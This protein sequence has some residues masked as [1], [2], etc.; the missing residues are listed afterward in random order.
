VIVATETFPLASVDNFNAI[1]D[2]PWVVGAFIW[3]AIDYIG[4]SVI[5]ANGHSPPD[6]LA[7]GDYC[8]QPWSYHIS[9]CGDLDVVGGQK[10]QAYLRRVLWNVSALEM[11]VKPA[12]DGEVIAAWGFPDERQ[13]WSWDVP[14]RLMQ[15]NVYSRAAVC[16]VVALNGKNVSSG[17]MPISRDTDYTLTIKV[18]YVPGTLTATGF[19][20]AGRVLATRSFVTAGPAAR[21]RLT[22]DRT[23]ISPSRAD[24]S[25]VV[26]EVVDAHGVLVT[27]ANESLGS[28][29]VPPT[30]RFTLEGDGE[31]AAVGSADP[32]DPSSFYAADADSAM[33]RKS[34]RGRA[35]AIVRPGKGAAAD[36]VNRL[37]APAQSEM[38]S[39][40]VAS[41]RR[42]SVG[43]LTLTAKAAGLESATVVIAVDESAKYK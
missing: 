16:V 30:I 38:G 13:S 40:L 25:Y 22:A 10:P 11:A 41:E 24:L 2:H 36:V 19:D 37:A 34:Y 23:K 42:P 5:G 1:R 21:L 27:C 12:D 26:A 43:L 8:P 6:P 18:A 29:C 14:Q 28:P 20:G 15:V 32:I 3:T 31:I 35:T 39:A 4:E 7:C 17:C 9:F 33:P